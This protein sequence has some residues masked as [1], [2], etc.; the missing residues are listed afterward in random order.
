MTETEEVT[1]EWCWPSK[2][3]ILAPSPA[4]VVPELSPFMFPTL[5]GAKL[6]APTVLAVAVRLVEAPFLESPSKPI[7]KVSNGA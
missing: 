5:P 6:N 7:P 4:Y 3:W 2:R 1:F